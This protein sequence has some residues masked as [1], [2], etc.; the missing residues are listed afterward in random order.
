MAMLRQETGE[1][2]I[3]SADGKT[4]RLSIP[5]I[6]DSDS[7]ITLSWMD[8]SHVA[9]SDMNGL[10]FLDLTGEIIWQHSEIVFYAWLDDG[11]PGYIDAMPD[12]EK[13]RPFIVE[14][15]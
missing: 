5:P 3:M 12:A 14:L 11:R 7:A 1:L 10:R 6:D 8:D 13:S 9:Y 2:F 4:T 15:E